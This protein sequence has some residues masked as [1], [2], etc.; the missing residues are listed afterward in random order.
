MYGCYPFCL[1]IHVYNN[2]S[3]FYQ[4]L[5]ANASDDHALVHSIARDSSYQVR[6]LAFNRMGDGV[7][8]DAITGVYS[9]LNKN[10][11]RSL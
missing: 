8:S 6:I 4:K 7:L 3:G 10:L 2:E 11:I 5:V 1:Q 9:S